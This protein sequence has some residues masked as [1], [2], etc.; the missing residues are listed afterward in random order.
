MVLK[1]PKV[2]QIPPEGIWAGRDK[3]TSVSLYR[4]NSLENLGKVKEIIEGGNVELSPDEWLI[5]LEGYKRQRANLN[6]DNS[7]LEGL[8]NKNNIRADDPIVTPFTAP[9][10][11]EADTDPELVACS[12]LVIDKLAHFIEENGIP[13]SKTAL[14]QLI[15]T[16]V[17]TVSK[18]LGFDD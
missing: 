1:S 17:E 18:K 9:I 2:M 5:L 15:R 7:Y 10:A 13:A 14:D 6:I 8:I 3:V 12:V 4:H 11:R 16:S